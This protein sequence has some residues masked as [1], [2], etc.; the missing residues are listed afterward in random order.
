[1]EYHEYPKMVYMHPVDKAGEHQTKIVHDR[2]QENTALSAGW[3]SH[4]HVQGTEEEA[5]QFISALEDSSEDRSKSKVRVRKAP[6][7]LTL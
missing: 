4:P 3:V 7:L 6:K 2:A 5:P 1:M